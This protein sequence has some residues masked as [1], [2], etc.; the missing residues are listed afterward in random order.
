MSRNCVSRN[1]SCYSLYTGRQI[2]SGQP[3]KEGNSRYILRGSD[4]VLFQRNCDMWEQV[5]TPGRFIFYDMLAETVCLVGFN[6]SSPN[7]QPRPQPT[8]PRPQPPQPG[9]GGVVGPIVEGARPNSATRAPSQASAP[10]FTTGSST[11]AYTST[12]GGIV[13]S[14]NT[15]T[16][17][18]IPTN[19]PLAVPQPV[20]AGANQTVSASGIG[21]GSTLLLGTVT[22]RSAIV[23]K[24]G[25]I[26]GQYSTN[27]TSAGVVQGRLAD[28][29]R[30][31]V[32]DNA[33]YAQAVAVNRGI[34]H[35]DK[36]ATHAGGIAMDCSIVHSAGPSSMVRGTASDKSMLRTGGMPEVKNLPKSST[37]TVARVGF[38]AMPDTN[39]KMF[40]FNTS[41]GC[42]EETTFVNDESQ[43]YREPLGVFGREQVL[44]SI[45]V[46]HA[47][48]VGHGAYANGLSAESSS[49]LA[50]AN[51][52]F[53]A[54][55]SMCNEVHMG[56]GLGA[57]V[58]GRAN[59]AVGAY[60]QGI[61]HNSLAYMHAQQAHAIPTSSRDNVGSDSCRIQHSAVPL[62]GFT[63]AEPVES[64][65]PRY[66]DQFML[67]TLLVLGDSPSDPLVDVENS[68]TLDYRR[69]PFLPVDGTAMVHVDLA[70][71]R[72]VTRNNDYTLDHFAGH[73]HF[74]VS[75][76]GSSHQFQYDLLPRTVGGGP[77]IGVDV[78]FP[79]AASLGL[80]ITAER[81]NGYMD[82][83]VVK[84]VEYVP[85]IATISGTPTPNPRIVPTPPSTGLVPFTSK[86]KYQIQGRL[87]GGYIETTTTPAG[88]TN[89]V[90]EPP[91]VNERMITVQPPVFAPPPQKAD[92]CNR[93][94]DDHLQSYRDQGVESMV[95]NS[96]GT[97]NDF[98]V[99][100]VDPIQ[101]LQA[102]N[103]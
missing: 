63:T 43:G 91:V 64:D 93:C 6:N 59:Q 77:D 31:I 61:G 95:A 80:Q 58:F 2:S 46:E 60:S 40:T 94:N 56:S 57:S 19:E 44:G 103:Y 12:P 25:D 97:T 3:G 8:P 9:E 34:V 35:A 53:A 32:S 47:S 11:G 33:A 45:G 79:S 87:W 52:S 17:T 29:S 14:T 73:Y 18:S 51:G 28:Q 83:Y 81:F 22:D 41:N 27:S 71:P 30:A 67:T 21:N 75:R 89:V 26:P 37:F 96:Y 50:T 7:P 36:D 10:I 15:L 1:D 4:N 42:K 54:G 66:Y 101:Q 38:G 90:Y 82:G 74:S 16:V 65:D 13:T 100:G 88:S 5:K 55:V 78:E 84:I 20:T 69:V 49:F 98:A 62:R 99:T 70:S 86:T 76:T 68:A 92:E 102:G 85:L 39:V 48:G 72:V 23:T 24:S